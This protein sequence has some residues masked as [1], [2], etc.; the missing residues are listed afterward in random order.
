[1]Q[2]END[3]VTGRRKHCRLSDIEQERPS[4]E[5]CFFSRSSSKL[6]RPFTLS[7]FSFSGEESNGIVEAFRCG[8]MGCPAVNEGR[9]ALNPEPNK[10]RPVRP[11]FLR[12]M[13]T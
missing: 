4:V 9:T 6:H 13:N 11:V 2:L 8:S 7:F 3:V 5:L 12:V 10:P 1:M